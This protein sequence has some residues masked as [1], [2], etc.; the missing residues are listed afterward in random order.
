MLHARRDLTMPTEPTPSL[1]EATAALRVVA[2]AFAD[3]AMSIASSL[4]G[5]EAEAPPGLRDIWEGWRRL[6]R[7]AGAPYGAG[8]EGLA[9]WLRSDVAPMLN[10][11]HAEAEAEQAAEQEAADG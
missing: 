6:Y 3:L 5:P 9:R 1:E 8:D 2:D 4:E 7:E 11:A 10:E